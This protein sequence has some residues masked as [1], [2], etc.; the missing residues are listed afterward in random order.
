MK[1][2]IK[3]LSYLLLLFLLT[4]EDCGNNNG[5]VSK[6]ERENEMFQKM[7]DKFSDVE[8]SDAS[9]SAFEKRAIQKLK[10][11]SDYINIYADTSL[12]VQFRKQ[13]GKMIQESFLE[14]ISLQKFFN[15]FDLQEDTMNSVLYHSE[16]MKIFKTAI[17]SIFI[18]D[19]LK[20]KSVSEYAGEIQFIQKIVLK[21]SAETV[22]S[23]TFRCRL[24]IMAIKTR[25]NFGDKTEDVW[26]VFLG[27]I[28]H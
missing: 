21:S 9:L 18:R 25:K 15:E 16:N 20:M 22:V 3:I 23:N 6:D 17:D 14:K 12:S 10:D 2:F 26:E 11:I 8:L 1:I 7:E 4:A 28:H 19:Q 27:E 24:N 5:Q 13:A